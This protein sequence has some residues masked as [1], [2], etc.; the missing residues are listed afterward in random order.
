MKD[1][2]L[3]RLA[4]ERSNPYVTISMNTHRTHPDNTVDA[5]GLK[6]LLS[7]ARNRISHEFSKHN[8]NNLLEKMNNLDHE[9]DHN[10]NLD[11]LHI[12]LSNTSKEIIRLA[13]PTQT[14][15]VHISNS[16]AIKPLIKVMNQT[17]EYYILLLSQSGVR[18]LYAI[19]DSISEEIMND[20]FPI[21]PKTH[22]LT[23]NEELVD[24]KQFDNMRNEYI[25][26]VDK[27]VF[28]EYN[29]KG[30]DC[31]VICTE[32]NYNRLIQVA[33]DP[34]IYY[35]YSN[36]NYNDTSDQN[37]ATHTWIMIKKLNH[38]FIEDAINE[39]QEAAGKGIASTNLSEINREV[40]K[41]RRA[42][43]DTQNDYHQKDFN[44]LKIDIEKKKPVL[45]KKL[46]TMSSD[47]RSILSKNGFKATMNYRVKSLYSIFNKIRNRNIT[48]DKIYDLMALR[49]ITDTVENCYSIL[50][51]IHSNWLHIDF[52]F[53]DWVS[54]PKPNG[55]RS[56]HT[57]V[58]D[59]KEEKFEIQIRT[60]EMHND[61]EFGSASH[62]T[63][64]EGICFDE[65]RL[66]KEFALL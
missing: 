27:A 22:F 64:K 31:I 7:E 14:N 16:F 41:G 9:I 36:M 50:D 44:K 28:K 12:F 46:N 6:N 2:K 33:D 57:T 34:S 61:A 1:E 30:L 55:Y 45:E 37:I 58:T 13:L 56:I 8:L 35:G 32:D 48:V 54:L 40:K 23:N 47:L 42:L 66:S 49:I 11:S 63:Y 17:E 21:A 20:D 3:N 25:N 53:R 18:L 29:R 4:I 10:H 5:I 38:K 24:G 65:K 43:I 15:T 19:N 39:M 51:L 60:K 59:S 52:R 26:K 62:S